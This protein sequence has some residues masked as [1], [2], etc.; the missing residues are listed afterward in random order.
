MYWELLENQSGNSSSL[1]RIEL[2]KKCIKLLGKDR[3][4]RIIGDREFIGKDWIGYLVREKIGF[5]F[6]VPK[7]HQ[8]LLKNGEQTNVVALLKEKKERYFSSVIVDSNKCNLFVKKLKDDYLFLVSNEESKA[9]GGI[10]K[11]RWSI[12]VLF[13]SCKKRGRFAA[14][15]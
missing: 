5:C 4:L 6:R 14:A 2:L 9:L 3:I 13:Q 1:A 8:I 7:H 10:Y 12:E 15:I 11:L